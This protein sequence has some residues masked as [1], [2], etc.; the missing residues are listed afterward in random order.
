M[1]RK[2][3]NVENE[4]AG[5]RSQRMRSRSGSSSCW[6][7]L[8]CRCVVRS[9][10]RGAFAT[11]HRGTGLV[12][13]ERDR[14]VIDSFDTDV[15]CR[16]GCTIA[17]TSAGP[18]TSGRPSLREATC[19]GGRVHRRKIKM[20]A[21]PNPHERA[22]RTHPYAVRATNRYRTAPGGD[23][24]GGSTVASRGYFRTKLHTGYGILLPLYRLPGVSV[25]YRSP[26]RESSSV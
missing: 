17:I 10:W 14:N 5:P 20:T 12:R 16:I 21:I 18:P 13:L 9:G 26:A 6:H 11:P 1:P 7:V 15:P 23:R 2:A 19:R 4:G 24:V 8:R 3:R 25:L 22:P